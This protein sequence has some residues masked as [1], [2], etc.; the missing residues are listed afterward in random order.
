[1]EDKS[2][3]DACRYGNDAASP[4]VRENAEGKYRQDGQYSDLDQDQSHEPSLSCKAFGWTNTRY[5]PR[6]PVFPARLLATIKRPPTQG[7]K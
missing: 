4:P 3:C 2:S 5:A 7:G 6:L 1:M